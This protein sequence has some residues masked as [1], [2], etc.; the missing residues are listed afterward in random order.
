MP[1]PA[2][3]S[4][5]QYELAVNL[6]LLCGG[7]GKFTVPTQRA[8]K[9]LG[10]DI[11]LVPA[12]RAAWSHFGSGSPPVGSKRHPGLPFSASLFIQ[13]KRPE[14][15][16]GHRAGQVK[17]R[18]L[19]VVGSPVPYL[20][21]RLAPDQLDALMRLQAQVGGGAEVCYAVAG[22]ISRRQLHARQAA[23]E[24]MD[25]S[26]FLSM[27]KIEETR[28]SYGLP[29][30]KPGEKHVWTFEEL[31][32]D[33]VLCSEPMAVEGVGRRGLMEGLL[34]RARANG[35]GLDRHL[36]TLGDAVLSWDSEQRRA[37]TR[38]AEREPPRSIESERQ[39]SIE[40]RRVPDDEPRLE[41]GDSRSMRKAI[42]VYDAA[43]S[44]GLD[45][46][47]ALAWPRDSTSGSEELR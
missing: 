10:F 36:D 6:E 42:D 39:L 27:R 44:R 11:E 43:R 33:G 2:E 7:S 21:Y 17:C 15:L 38:E 32:T 30:V 4:E 24:V 35:P 22:F 40:W 41:G 12:L 37:V 9:I 45:W 25:G 23:G 14:M 18:R 16:V 47:L 5:R 28:K 1:R 31:R 20:R 46:H 26:N 34:R 29:P 8:E 13:Y 19:K 3:F